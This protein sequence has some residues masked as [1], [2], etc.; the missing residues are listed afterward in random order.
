MPLSDTL[1]LATKPGDEWPSPVI[2]ELLRAVFAP[3]KLKRPATVHLSVDCTGNQPKCL[4]R[5]SYRLGNDLQDWFAGKILDGTAPLGVPAYQAAFAPRPVVVNNYRVKPDHPD[6]VRRVLLRVG[7]FALSRRSLLRNPGR[8]GSLLHTDAIVPLIRVIRFAADEIDKWVVPKIDGPGKLAWIVP[9]PIKAVIEAC[10]AEAWGTA[11]A[12]QLARVRK[13]K[14]ARIVEELRWH[15]KWGALAEVRVGHEMGVHGSNAFEDCDAILTFKVRP[16]LG[17][18]W[19]AAQVLRVNP[20]GYYGYLAE[21]VVAQHQARIRDLSA[22]PG[23]PKLVLQVSSDA[24]AWWGSEPFDL[25]LGK[26]GKLPDRGQSKIIDLYVELLKQHRAV[27]APLIDWIANHPSAYVHAFGPTVSPLADRAVR[28]TGLRPG[29]R[30]ADLMTA[31]RT[32]GLPHLEEAVH[33]PGQTCGRRWTWHH[34]LAGAPDRLVSALEGALAA[35][36]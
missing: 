34:T 20:V 32:C 6:E 16:N 22:A 24:P 9:K 23:E 28:L 15:I 1:R 4:F 21:S 30:N 12:D 10:V 35:A 13:N 33:G 25:V 5:L 17:E 36:P 2:D 31:L 11:S 19:R 14:A 26:T 29:L 7:K 3:Q 8:R 27:A 18:V